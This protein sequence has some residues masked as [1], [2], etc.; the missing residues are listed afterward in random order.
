MTDSPSD[1]AATAPDPFAAEVASAVGSTRFT[2][3]HATVKVHVDPA[4]WVAAITT[5]RDDFGLRFFSYL[6][7]TD[8][9]RDSA[10]GEPLEDP[11]SVTERFEVIA[12]VSSVESAA[13]IHFVADL[14]KDAASIDSLGSVY[15]GALWHERECHEMFGID[16]I[17]NSNLSNLY[18]PDAFEGHPLRKDYPLLSREVKPWPGKVDVEDKP[19]TENPEAGE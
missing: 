3:D 15:G 19:S 18:L 13:S 8:W 7:A 10:V 4:N 1:S 9:S 11:D 16:F 6:S 17:G 2:S 12:R 14:P 5:A